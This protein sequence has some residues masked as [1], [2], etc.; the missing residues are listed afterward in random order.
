MPDISNELR[1]ILE[2][3]YGNEVRGSIHDAIKAGNDAIN[4]YGE[5][6]SER[7]Q[8]EEQRASE[9]TQRQSN[10]EQR[11]LLYEE[12]QTYVNEFKE[13]GLPKTDIVN[14]IYPVGSIYLSI[15][16]TD[17]K[18]IFGGTW[19]RFGNGRTLVGVDT[20]Q[21][22]FNTVEKTGGSKTHKLTVNEMPAHN[23]A[24]IDSAG[25]KEFGT[26]INQESTA[27]R[28]I[29]AKS[30]SVV[31][32]PDKMQKSGGDQAHNNLQPYITVYMWK[33]TA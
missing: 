28:L 5:S 10:E 27:S 8:A 3:T 31:S 23:H 4:E 30:Y 25:N 19:V 2:A 12:M 17:P 29:Y 1:A 22:E 32:S 20:L 24:M 14:L 16:P 18:T 15:S 9:E 26:T 13:S 7:V 6:E 33:R 11:Q 21:T